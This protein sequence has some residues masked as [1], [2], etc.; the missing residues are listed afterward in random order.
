MAGHTAQEELEWG[1]ETRYQVRCHYLWPAHHPKGG[2]WGRPETSQDCCSS[3][4]GYNHLYWTEI[5]RGG[6]LE[7]A[8]LPLAAPAYPGNGRSGAGRSM[9]IAAPA[10]HR[11][12][13]LNRSRIALSV[14]SR[15]PLWLESPPSPANNRS[16]PLALQTKVAPDHNHRMQEATADDRS[17]IL[18]LRQRLPAGSGAQAAAQ[19][20]R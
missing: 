10:W 4:M 18:R 7:P 8:H 6:I 14:P 16:Y 2:I 19:L 1:V 12:Y 11:Y 20:L 3:Y 13:P 15:V 5:S 17:R 9:E